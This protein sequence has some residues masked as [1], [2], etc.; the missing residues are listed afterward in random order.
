MRSS[1][2]NSFNKDQ[3]LNNIFRINEFNESRQIKKLFAR[4]LSK[5]N[6]EIFFTDF[7]GLGFLL[8]F[9]VLTPILIIFSIFNNG[10]TKISKIFIPTENKRFQNNAEIFKHNYF[11]NQEI[12]VSSK[13]IYAN[14]DDIIFLIKILNKYKLRKGSLFL[15]AKIFFSISYLRPIIDK[16]D[17]NEICMFNEWDVA[18]PTIYDYLKLNNI[19]YNLLMHGDK[20]YEYADAFSISDEFYVWSY[21]YVEVFMDLCV[22][23]NYK[24][25][26]FPNY[27]MFNIDKNNS[28]KNIIF[29]PPIS[30]NFSSKELKIHVKL[31]KEFIQSYSPSVKLHPKHKSHQI[32]LLELES[33][34]NIIDIIEPNKSTVFIGYVSTMLLRAALSG[35]E[36]KVI[37]CKQTLD[38]SRYHPLFLMDNV[39][40]IDFKD[41]NNE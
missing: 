32:E 40:L 11:L 5:S 18:N 21:S 25:I 29:T 13:L 27:F 28:L 16:Y 7:L 20:A 36:V 3:I 15:Y 9:L 12:I 8:L 14:F 39:T 38:M 24:D 1:K 23:S 35:L 6:F 17:P 34:N 41:I 31:I 26:G 22:E 33:Y 30:R 2:N 10:R 37:K 4:N 19:K